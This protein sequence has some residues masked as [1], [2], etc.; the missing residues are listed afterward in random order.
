MKT[1]RL[2]VIWL[3]WTRACFS[4]PTAELCCHLRLL[5]SRD[6]RFLC[7][8]YRRFEFHPSGQSVFP[9]AD[10]CQ[11]VLAPC[12]IP[13]MRMKYRKVFLSWHVY[14]TKY[15]IW[16]PK[17]NRALGLGFRPSMLYNITKSTNMVSKAII[18]FK[19]WWNIKMSRKMMEDLIYSRQQWPQKS[20]YF[21]M[22]YTWRCSLSLRSRVAM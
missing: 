13:S 18:R 15:K 16:V 11:K 22:S 2:T 19:F 14:R 6:D 12:I 21:Q 9:I 10:F 1:E 5:Q 8:R 3:L 17:R 20:Q 7:F 4:Y